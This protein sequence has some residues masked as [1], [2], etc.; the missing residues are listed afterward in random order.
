MRW[1]I[2]KHGGGRESC[3]SWSDE[4]VIALIAAW[5]DSL[6]HTKPTY[7]YSR[8]PHSLPL[9]YKAEKNKKNKTAAQVV[10]G[11]RDEASTRLGGWR[12]IVS[13][14]FARSTT[15]LHP[16]LLPL[17][18]GLDSYTFTFAE[19]KTLKIY[20]CKRIEAVYFTPI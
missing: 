5:G 13:M 2:G 18:S 17:R 6:L 20:Q 3:A 9:H 12:S 14:R 1:K 19:A 11:L 7:M 4:E 15:K 10:L 8:R 16:H